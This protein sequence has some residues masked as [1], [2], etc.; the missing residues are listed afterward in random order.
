MLNDEDRK[1][2]D[3]AVA[4]ARKSIGFVE[5]NPP[6]GAVVVQDGQ[7]VGESWHKAWG[8]PHAEV[9][10]LNMARAR[11]KGATV[12]VSLEPCSRAGKTPACTDR[13]IQAGVSRVVYAAH[14]PHP[15]QAGRADAGLREAGIEV[16]GPA[17]PDEG[18]ALLVRFLRALQADRPWTIAKWAMTL[19]GRITAAPGINSRIYGT[20]AHLLA[21]VH[22]ARMDAIAVGADTV[23]VDD[24]QLTC[25]LESG[26]PDGRVQPMR[27]VFATTLDIPLDCK[28]VRTAKD[29]PVLVFAGPA[30]PE[31][32]RDALEAAGCQVVI[33]PPHT[34]GL[35]LRMALRELRSRGI[36]RLLVEG[37]GQVHGSMFSAGLID[38][39]SAFVAPSIVGSPDPV[40]PVVGTPIAT[41]DDAVRL[42]DVTWRKVGDDLFL[43]GFV[44]PR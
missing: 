20:K 19:D 2:L 13:L 22:R 39:V 25:R 41:M 34:N 18:E 11:A 30:A 7:V 5:P 32:R 33:V 44:D 37:G 23:R 3:R 17:A 12:F 24:P 29:V 28:M 26:L 15:D 36:Q 38:Q 4:L 43:N 42:Q 40:V 27:V 9:L 8:G 10:A 1:R 16:I 6:V 35:D 21:H 14:D 31:D